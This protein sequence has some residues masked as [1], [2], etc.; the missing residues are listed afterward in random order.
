M[1]GGD[2]VLLH[3]IFI[4]RELIAITIATAAKTSLI[5]R[6][7]AAS[8]LIALVLSLSICQILANFAGVEF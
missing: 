5:K 2:E 7:L 4:N 1:P 6:I 8:E 3:M